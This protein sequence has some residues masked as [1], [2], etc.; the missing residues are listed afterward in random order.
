MA[1]TTQSGTQH[2]AE[3]HGSGAFPPF[4][5]ETFASQIVWLAIAFGLL[6]LLMSRIALPQVAAILE[7]RGKRIA[8]DLDAAQASK[9]ESEAAAAAY[10]ASLEQ[11]RSRAQS[12]TGETRASMHAEAETTRKS[13]EAEL[14]AKLASAEESIAGTKEAAL[15]S[16]RGIASEAASAIVERLTGK[17]PDR[18]SVEA[19][20]DTAVRS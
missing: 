11:A 10:E 18:K 19:A 4:A 2:P 20:V 9:A 12:I 13:L 6:Y 15:G 1:E 8:S 14:H 17:A 5:S 7:A 16:V 3:G